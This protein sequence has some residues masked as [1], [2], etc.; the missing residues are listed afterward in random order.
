MNNGHGSKW[1]AYRES[2]KN[3]ITFLLRR[4]FEYLEV[5]ENLRV[6]LNFI[7]ISNT[8][9]SQEVEDNGVWWL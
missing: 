9:L 2:I 7:V 3:L 4:L 8:V 6:N 5:F 1:D